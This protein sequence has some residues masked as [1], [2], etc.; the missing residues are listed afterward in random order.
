LGL[1]LRTIS[2]SAKV[3]GSGAIAVIAPAD[4][5]GAMK[6]DHRV[7]T[8]IFD[9]ATGQ[10]GDDLA[11]R[12]NGS[13]RG[14]QSTAVSGPATIVVGKSNVTGV[15][16]GLELPVVVAPECLLVIDRSKD[17]EVLLATARQNAKM[18]LLVRSTGG[19][20][21]L[22]LAPRWRTTDSSWVG[23]P[24]AVAEA[25][26][27]LSQWILFLRHAAGEEAWHLNGHYAN[28]TIDDPWLT[29][30]Y[31]RM[32]YRALTVEMNEHNFH[33][34]IAFIPWNFARSE[35]EVVRIFRSNPAR[36]S[37]SMHGNDH[38]HREFGAYEENPLTLQS[39]DLR[40]SVAR[41][42]RFRSLTGIPYDR[43]MIFPH[44]VAPLPT[45]AELRKLDF[46]GTAN[47]LNVPL[48]VSYPNDPT[49]LLRTY[50]NQ[51][52]N[53][54][55][56]FRYFAEG[57][58]PRTEIAIHSYLGNP[59]LF[60]GHE[61]LFQNGPGSF[62]RFAD[63]VNQL[64][65]ATTWTGLGDIARNLYMTRTRSDAGIDVEMLSNEADLTNRTGKD[66]VFHV[67]YQTAGEALALSIDGTPGT[68]SRNGDRLIFQVAIP[69]GE[70][71]KI[72]LTH[73]E[74]LSAIKVDP[75]KSDLMTWAL[76]RASDV[77][78]IY[79][80]RSSAG[81]LFAAFYYRI[82]LNSVQQ[83]VERQWGLI[84]LFITSIIVFKRYRRYRKSATQ[85]VKSDLA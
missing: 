51:Y 15:L 75:A 21:E 25:F 77:R 78:D 66:I 22:F 73:P 82:G 53:E 67:G 37:V 31:G 14:C 4:A 18:P 11:S 70:I 13:V 44:A 7:P 60:Y 40:Q 26:T 38:V 56:L 32:D 42:E 27:S 46:A 48:G 17:I 5:I 16:G 20:A 8:L 65:P 30:Q 39:A 33:T 52:G 74:A 68:F 81:S 2:P 35:D 9:I 47:S 61:S 45:F 71:R 59:L 49:F 10:N 57:S 76:R 23:D 85:Q 62:N 84:L 58:I 1:N 12:S 54:L 69:A 72:R 24:L 55:S 36:W 29:R 43:F 34:T 79:L 41:M 19:G 3:E 64:E 83:H 28:L 63:V 6:W 50:T 80:S